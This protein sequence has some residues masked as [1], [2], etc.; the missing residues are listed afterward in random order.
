MFPGKTIWT[1]ASVYRE[2]SDTVTIVFDTNRT[3]FHYQA[4]QFVSVSLVIDGEAASRSY[5]LSSCPGND[6]KPSITV[7]KID[8]GLVSNYIF[9]HAQEIDT[10]TIDGP[11]GE[12]YP[13]QDIIQSK[14]I[15]LLAAGSGI[16]PI[17][18][19]LKFLLTNSE[20][21]V[22]LI[23][24]T[25]T[26][27]E[28]IFK[29]VLRYLENT[30]PDR[31]SIHY[32]F[33]AEKGN[34]GFDGA[35]YFN[36]RISK[37]VLK[38]LLGHLKAK[39]KA[40][41]FVCGLYAFIDFAIDILKALAIEEK[42]IHKEYFTTPLQTGP[43]LLRENPLEVLLHFNGQTNLL[44]VHSNQTILDAALADMIPVPYS[45]KQGACGVCIGK[46]TSGKLYMKNNYMLDNAQVA[47]G[48]VLLCQSYPLDNDVTVE[49]GAI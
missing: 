16:T 18:S 20:V 21:H 48:A 22:T 25:K 1:T 6:E 35:S 37:L 27:Q 45:C 13:Q 49:A 24:S 38:R 31:F 43:S 12:F 14:E 11:F 19:I 9:H 15:V 30:Y 28:T 2:T 34:A 3:F 17:F 26:W 7:K 47:A 33:T 29:S 42:L 8:N 36:G 32:F 4:G 5:S 10:W 46:Q 23:Y 39:E 40:H 44:E 41:Y